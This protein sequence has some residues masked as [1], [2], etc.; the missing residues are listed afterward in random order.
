MDF[1]DVFAHPAFVFGAAGL[2]AD[3]VLA[4]DATSGEDKRVAAGAAFGGGDVFGEHEFAHADDK[5]ANVHYWRAFGFVLV[6]RPLHRAQFIKAI[7]ADAGE[8]RSGAGDL[9]HD[10]LRMVV[11]HRIAQR[12]A[13]LA[14]GLPFGFARERLHGLAHA[15]DAALGVGE[16]AV[17]FQKAGAGEDHVGVFTAFVVKDILDDDA[18]HGAQ[19]LRL[20]ERCWGRIAPGLRLG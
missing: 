15:V 7:V 4:Q 16:G 12:G 1:E 2:G 19:G 9:R 11:A 3:V 5:F 6:A 8:A 17:F 14:D 10:L 20:R 13:E 18:V